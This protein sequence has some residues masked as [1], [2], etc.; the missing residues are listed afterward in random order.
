[1]RISD[2]DAMNDKLYKIVDD[3][4]KDVSR[5]LFTSEVD[6]NLELRYQEIMRSCEGTLVVVPAV[7]KCDTSST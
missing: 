5:E 4:G 1:M 3:D 7:E 2:D 6:A